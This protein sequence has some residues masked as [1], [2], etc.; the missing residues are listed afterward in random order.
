MTLAAPAELLHDER[1]QNYARFDVGEHLETWPIRSAAFKNWLRRAY[2]QK[3]GKPC[4]SQPMD[5]AMG[6]LEAKAQF[7]GDEYSLSVRC[8]SR[9]GSIWIDMAD[10][11]WRAIEVTSGGWQIVDLPPTPTFRRHASHLPLAE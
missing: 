1:G 11:H 4:G 3:H 6:T 2:Y 10:K 5:D 7:D 8:A 9:D